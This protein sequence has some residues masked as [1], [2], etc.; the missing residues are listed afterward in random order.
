LQ[1]DEPCTNIAYLLL[2]THI[3]LPKLDA[4][5]LGWSLEDAK[6]GLQVISCTERYQEQWVSHK[7]EFDILCDGLECTN[8][9]ASVITQHTDLGRPLKNDLLAIGNKSLLSNHSLTIKD[10]ANKELTFVLHHTD[11][12]RPTSMA[13]RVQ[14]SHERYNGV[15]HPKPYYLQW[16]KLADLLKHINKPEEITMKMLHLPPLDELGINPIYFLSSVH[17]ESRKSI[18]AIPGN[19]LDLVS[20]RSMLYEQEQHEL[21]IMHPKGSE[22]T[23]DDT[24][25]SPQGKIFMASLKVLMSMMLSQSEDVDVWQGC[26]VDLAYIHGT[27]CT[28]FLTKIMEMVTYLKLK[29]IHGCAIGLT[30]A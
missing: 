4:M 1:H 18:V 5:M 11:I 13:A 16:A 9:Y 26:T 10:L 17:T 24:S 20:R 12:L 27:T 30:F 23:C 25:M 2:P 3:E 21:H 8:G 6:I 28:R 29:Q 15:E 22:C 19:M 14:S 7:K